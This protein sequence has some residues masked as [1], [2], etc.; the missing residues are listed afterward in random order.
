ML[1]QKIVLR[2]E[3]G[4]HARP[5]SVFTRTANN[6]SSK[7]TIQKGDKIIDAKSILSL[8]SLGVSKGTEINL[9]VDGDDEELAFNTLISLIERGFGES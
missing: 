3:S 9:M 8:L 5:A 1:S 7:V 4:L 2:N 6:F